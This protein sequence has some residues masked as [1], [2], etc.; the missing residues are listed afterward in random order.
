MSLPGNGDWNKGV[1]ELAVIGKK[2]GAL[3][4]RHLRWVIVGLIV[5][6]GA[7]TTYY[8]IE[9]EE[10]GVITRFGRYVDTAEPGPHFRIP[11]GVERVTKVPVQRQLKAEFGFRTIHAG[12]RTQYADN[13]ESAKEALMLTG[14]LNV[15]TVEWIVQYKIRD[16]RAYLFNVRNVGDTLRYMSEATMRQVV[17]DH[18][19]T[20]VLTIGREQIQQK[21]KDRMQELCNQYGMGVEILQLV[22]QDVNPPEPVRPSFNDVNQA[23]QER[24]RR[25]NEA[26]AE[27]NRAIPEARGM[28][29]QVLQAAEGYATERVNR[30][31][32]ETERYLS[33]LAEYT[34]SPKVTRARLY[35]EAMNDIM[36]AAG[37]RIVLDS[38]AKGLLPLLNLGGTG[39]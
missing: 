30:A 18:S 39:R 14:D 2:A 27:Y 35:L 20:E 36:P 10:V 33:L 8:Q 25:I 5:F 12:E 22:L 37:Q 3:A 6:V 26:W 38:A 28:A 32:G 15:A 7:S 31:R 4:R 1:D 11:F 19:V 9:P 17:G 34:K 21:A 13:G 16:P 29:E 24:E 23:T